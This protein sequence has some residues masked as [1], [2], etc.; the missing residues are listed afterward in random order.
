MI[1][2]LDDFLLVDD[3]EPKFFGLLA[4]YLDLFEKHSKRE[5]EFQVNFLGIQIDSDAMQIR[6]SFDKHQHALKA[7]NEFL[8]KNN[9]IPCQLEQLVDFLSFCARV[10]PLGRPFLRNTFNLLR[11]ISHFHPHSLCRI[12]SEAKR[13][14]H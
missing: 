9:I 14:I 4:A 13:D 6:L 1:H 7:V 5:D 8:F 2:Y 10:I 12:T 11:K 3:S